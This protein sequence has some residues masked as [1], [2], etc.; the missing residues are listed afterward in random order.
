MRFNFPGDSGK[1][2]YFCIR[3]ENAKGDTGDWGPV[4]SAVIP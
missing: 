2:A 3:Y 4:F 1:T